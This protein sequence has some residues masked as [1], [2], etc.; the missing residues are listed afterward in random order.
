[1]IIF[2]YQINKYIHKSNLLLFLSI[3]SC[4]FLIIYLFALGF[5]GKIYRFMREIGIFVFF[6][7]S[8]IC[9]ALLVFLISDNKIR[10]KFPLRI[11][12][13]MYLLFIVGYLLILPFDNPNYENVIE[14][15]FALFI[16][17]FFPLFSGLLRET[18]A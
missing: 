14:W 1:M 10:S 4:I 3:T 9:Q 16:F 8:P 18:N 12:L 11:L 17:L 5:E 7:L 6:I 15:N 13:S 2:W